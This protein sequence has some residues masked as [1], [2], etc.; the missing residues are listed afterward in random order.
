MKEQSPIQIEQEENINFAQLF[1]IC[2]E[3]LR[4]RWYWFFLSVIVCLVIGYVYCEKQSRTYQRQS[5]MLIEDG[6]PSDPNFGGSSRR[7]RNNMTSLMELNGISVGDNLENEIFILTS[8]RLMENV[9]DSLRLDVDYTM[10][11]GLHNVTLY[12]ERPVEVRF[13]GRLKG[14][15][16][17][18]MKMQPAGEGKYKL[19]NFTKNNAELG[20][21][22]IAEIGKLTDTPVGKLTL[23]DTKKAKKFPHDGEIN[24]TRVSKKTA[25]AIFRA[26]IS[27]AE[28]DKKSTLI[29]LTCKDNNEQRAEDVL[30]EVFKA[31]KYD[32][33]E[34]K[35]RVAESTANF[36]DSRIKLIGGELD[37]IE[38][39][40][41]EFKSKNKLIDFERDAQIFASENANARAR[42]LEAETALA[43]AELLKEH[44]LDNSNDGEMIPTLNLAGASYGS[45]VTEYNKLMAERQQLVQNTTESAE[46]IISL[47][48]KLDAMRKSI[49]SSV[50]S[51]VKSLELQVKQARNH[52]AKFTTRI[53]SVPE[54]E[55][56]AVSIERQQTL[57]SALYNYLLNKREEVALQLAINEAN[58]RMVEYPMGNS[59]PIAPRKNII[60]LVSLLLGFTIPAGIIWLCRTVDI[61][62]NGRKDIEDETTIPIVGELPHW[63][64]GQRGGLI[65]NCGSNEPIVEAF[66]VMRYS[67]N[68]VKPNAKVMICT[69]STP[70]QGKSFVSRNFA[71]IQAMAGHRVLLI[72]ADVRKATLTKY[73]GGMNGLTN[74][75]IDITG[76]T[77]IDPYVM[78]DTLVENVDF[79]PAGNLPPNPT[80]LLMSERLELLVEDAKKKYDYVI[81]DATPAFSVADA[82]I[83]SRVAELLLFV[84]RVGVQDRAFLPEL[85]RMHQNKRMKNL[86]IVVNDADKKS[87][88]HYG[89]GY[90]YGYGRSEQRH[91]RKIPFSKK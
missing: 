68:F 47:D 51:H 88:I 81:F 11:S 14:K 10:K 83:L 8:L 74:Y 82:E 50:E 9:V 72:D 40:M 23:V 12:S 60:L 71:V 41:A 29:V 38:D 13:Q 45:L 75:L 19:Y 25:A 53:G 66:R 32:V 56:E 5:V 49:L 63:N 69:S 48:F 24:V 21:S 73:Y 61:T 87:K 33:V 2:R 31:Y 67:S 27:A 78:K 90:G 62:V 77:D 7:A 59:A 3:E 64:E 34:N 28:Y 46:A 1:S 54:T 16:S 91:K 6:N 39:R 43:V 86:A 4:R 17:V 44:L 55:K 79:L 30:N 35:N 76:S 20:G 26:K 80:E 42:T 52:E 84:I 18:T 70:G 89:Y 58:V 85:E 37:E 36:I 57:K 15:E 65:T 22:V